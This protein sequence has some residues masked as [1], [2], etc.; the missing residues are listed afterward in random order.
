MSSTLAR[1]SLQQRAA[2]ATAELKR[3]LGL[4]DLKLLSAAVAEVAAAQAAT[5]P[6]FAARIRSAYAEL[7][8][9]RGR[10]SRPSVAAPAP[11]A[12]LTPLPGSES[13]RFD[14]FA[15]LDPYVLLRIYGP[16]QLRDALSA[17]SLS[18]LREATAAVQARNPDTLPIDRRTKATLINYIVDCL[19]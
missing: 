5:H 3:I 19:T 14:P 9:L 16:E 1:A 6:D 2:A 7:A 18:A 8:A 10:R 11:R 4:D 15:P 13:I 17:Y 12:Q